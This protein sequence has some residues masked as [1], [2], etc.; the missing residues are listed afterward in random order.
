MHTTYRSLVHSLALDE[1]SK[2]PE[3]DAA[4]L[5]LAQPEVAARVAKI[6]WTPE[7]QAKSSYRRD[8]SDIR[9]V[10]ESIVFKGD[11]RFRQLIGWVDVLIK[12]LAII[13]VK[14]KPVA[15]TVVIRQLG[16]YQE[17]VQEWLN[18][19]VLPGVLATTYRLATAQD[20]AMLKSNGI[21]HIRLAADFE[22]FKA[23]LQATVSDPEVTI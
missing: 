15:I 9:P 19:T 18:E 8:L 1:D 17:F 22:A 11:G 13:E 7:V 4:C 10:V 5:Y 3:H 6:V 23:K 14:T 20:A 12:G 2:S 16:L 21:T